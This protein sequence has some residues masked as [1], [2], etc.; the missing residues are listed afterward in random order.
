MVLLFVIKFI[1][2]FVIKFSRSRPHYTKAK[3]AKKTK[4][5]PERNQNITDNSKGQLSYPTLLFQMT[6]VGY[7][8]CDWGGGG[9]G[10]ASFTFTNAGKPPSLIVCF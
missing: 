3:K 8:A 9:G 5:V 4:R 7:Q 2:L 6:E 10:K 1:L